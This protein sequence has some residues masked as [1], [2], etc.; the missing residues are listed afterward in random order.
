MFGDLS[1][2]QLDDLHAQAT[3][4]ADLFGVVSSGAAACPT[5]TGSWR[6]AGSVAEELGIKVPADLVTNPATGVQR[7]SAA[8]AL[9]GDPARW[10]AVERVNAGD[11]ADWRGDPRL[12]GLAAEASVGGL[13]YFFGMTLDGARGQLRYTPK[14]GGRLWMAITKVL[15]L[16]CITGDVA[17]V[18]AGHLCH[19]FGLFPLALAVLEELYVRARS[20]L[21]VARPLGAALAAE[22]RV[23]CGLVPGCVADLRRRLALVMTCTDAYSLPVSPIA[24][25]DCFQLAR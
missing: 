13:V 25:R 20:S 11:I 15:E 10:V 1:E 17:R 3:R 8:L 7:D 22:L 2:G 9:F 23:A 14:R 18:L 4:L 5:G 16:G 21:G 24:A 19:Q 6:V 12:G